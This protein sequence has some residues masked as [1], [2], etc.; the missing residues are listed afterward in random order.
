MSDQMA[1]YAGASQETAERA[2][3]L[4][5]TIIQDGREWSGVAKFDNL[6]LTFATQVV[7][8]SL[9][10]DRAPV[11]QICSHVASC[12]ALRKMTETRFG[13]VT[14]DANVAAPGTK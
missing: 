6:G 8:P 2:A 12:N 7:T 3:S 1:G 10:H 4:S 9:H 14:L 13:H 5:W 11:I